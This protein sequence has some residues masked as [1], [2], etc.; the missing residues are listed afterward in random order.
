MKSKR[1][2]LAIFF[3]VIGAFRIGASDAQQL[4][5]SQQARSAFESTEIAALSEI[6]KS[7]VIINC[8]DLQATDVFD[9]SK[10]LRDDKARKLIATDQREKK[11]TL[12]NERIFQNFSLGRSFTLHYELKAALPGSYRVECSA[13]QELAIESEYSL[14][15]VVDDTSKAQP[16]SFRFRCSQPGDYCII[17]N[18]KSQE[19][20]GPVGGFGNRALF[21]RFDDAGGRLLNARALLLE[22]KLK[23]W[24]EYFG[25]DADMLGNL[26]EAVIIDKNAG[27]T[28]PGKQPAKENGVHDELQGAAAARITVSGR[29][30]YMDYDRS[31]VPIQNASVEIYDENT[32]FLDKLLRTAGT[33][34]NGFYSAQVSNAETGPFDGR[35]ADIYIR[36][37][38]KTFDGGRGQIVIQDDVLGPIDDDWDVM[39]GQNNNVTQDIIKNLQIGN[40]STINSNA[41]KA[42][43]VF[44]HVL[45]SQEFYTYFGT[46]LIGGR[47]GEL[48]AFYP[49]TTP[50]DASYF[51][52]YLPIGRPYISYDTDRIK[53]NHTEIPSEIWHEYGHFAM[54]DVFN[55]HL[56]YALSDIL[57]LLIFGHNINETTSRVIAWAE[58]WADF[59]AIGTRDKI[60]NRQDAEYFFSN[61][62]H[63][64]MKNMD[65]MDPV[66]GIDN[67]EGRVAGAMYDLYDTE[68]DENEINDN[69]SGD[70]S[71]EKILATMASRRTNTFEEF[72]KHY[73]RLHELQGLVLGACLENGINYGIAPGMTSLA[74]DRDNFHP[75]DAVDEQF[76]SDEAFDIAGCFDASFVASH[77]LDED[78]S[79]RAIGLTHTFLSTVFPTR[80]SAAYLSFRFRGNNGGVKN[81][82]I[83]FNTSCDN[84]NKIKVAALK[85]LLGGREPSD[86][87]T[88]TVVVDLANV[89]VRILDRIPPSNV[90]W[91]GGPDKRIDLTNDLMNE[92]GDI[93]LDL[94]FLDCDLTLDYSEFTV[95]LGPALP[96]LASENLETQPSTFAMLQNYPNP[97]NPET[98]IQFALPQS[99]KVT[100]RIYDILGREVKTIINARKEAGSYDVVWD[101]K[102]A[103][104]RVVASGIYFYRIEVRATNGEKFAATKKMSLLR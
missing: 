55:Q 16:F 76:I 91:G 93:Q 60:R 21:F 40:L 10:R 38:A 37:F 67:V 2:V 24:T 47:P 61:G 85:D 95:M 1:F 102:D 90:S 8:L 64:Q 53:S 27:E 23:I 58:G 19:E 48:V 15:L 70:R 36:V 56:P 88:H 42:F 103:L 49:E 41:N 32:S 92:R 3:A 59:V 84:S 12:A 6:H 44:D 87:E 96:K 50:G 63:L 71:H 35:T 99:G 86:G 29:I 14:Q 97:F 22:D 54:W 79:D 13:T 57:E 45:E 83:A 39:S 74:G 65:E 31:I 94:V 75:G 43:A 11:G 20:A 28:A 69:F 51:N 77:P 34:A 104:G 80:H 73:I 33:D 81:D 82:F 17:V 52:P 4:A 101:S 78:G 98:K 9:L 46:R 25:S 68:D 100:L 72:I 30:T 7:T 5:S 89:P 18:A 62:S 26:P 66:T